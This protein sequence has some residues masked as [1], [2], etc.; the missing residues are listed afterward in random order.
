MKGALVFCG[1]LLSGCHAPQS[2]AA[3]A[4]ARTGGGFDFI[5]GWALER[6][7]NLLVTVDVGIED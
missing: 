4:P 7:R 5:A 2:A 3:A 6:D 1:G